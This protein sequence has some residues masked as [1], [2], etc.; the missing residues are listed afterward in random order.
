MRAIRA[1]ATSGDLASA[2]LAARNAFDAGLRHPF[3]YNVI[4]MDL[5]T[6]GK[7]P[8]AIDVLDE[9]LEQFPDD[10]ACLQAR[11]LCLLR[12]EQPEAAR[13]DFE[14]VTTLKPDFAPGFTALGQACEACGQLPAAESRYRRALA[15]DATNIMAEAG[16]ASVLGRRGDH[17]EAHERALRVL[18]AEPNY[19]PASLVAA[20][21]EV[22]LKRP[23]EA[24]AR[25][26]MLAGAPR[27]RRR[28][29]RTD[30]F[31]RR[32]FAGIE[33]ARRRARQAGRRGRCLRRL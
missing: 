11:G 2:G 8:E 3:L 33:R 14:R 17:H 25:M 1:M 13:A 29:A 19:P 15:L 32:A 10:L 30:R 26:R 4:A 16:L 12:T 22:A 5:E 9:A 21:A 7:L 20:E 28:Q 6:A 27:R 24:Q 23:A 18:A 31:D